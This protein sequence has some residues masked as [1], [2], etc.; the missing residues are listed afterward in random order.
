MRA[1][2]ATE[3]GS[4][5]AANEDW[6]GVLAPGLAIVLDGLSAPDGTGTG[7]R[8]GTPWY[9]NQLGPRLL[10]LAS[11]PSRSLADALA[12]AI[13]QVASLPSRVRPDPSRHTVRHRR[14]APR[15]RGPP[16]QWW[17][18]F[19]EA[20]PRLVNPRRQPTEPAHDQAD[21]EGEPDRSKPAEVR[22][23]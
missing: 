3:S 9:V 2:L 11:D 4:P 17:K 12:E 16:Q 6:G 22:K 18:A 8:H 7:C 20:Y 1:A 15:P 23:H 14:L 19:A 21:A 5:D 13:R 10:A